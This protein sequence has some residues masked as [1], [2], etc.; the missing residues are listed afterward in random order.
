MKKWFLNMLVLALAAVLLVPVMAQDTITL[1]PF[2]DETFGIQGLMPEGWVTLAPGSISPDGGLTVLVQQAAPGVTPEQLLQALAP[3]LMLAEVPE[4]VE[5][6]EGD[7]L[8]W[9]V[10]FVEVEV[11]GMTILVDLALSE[12]DGATYLVLL[13]ASAEQYETLHFDVFEPVL[14]AYAPLGADNSG[15]PE[16]TAA[17]EETQNIYTDPDGLYEVEIPTN[18]TLEEG[19]GYIALVGPEGDLSYSILTL[20]TDDLTASIDDAWAIFGVLE[21]LDTNYD[22]DMYEHI[23]DQVILDQAGVEDVVVVTYEDGTNDDERIVQLVSQL[24]DGVGYYAMVQGDVSALQRRLA[25]LQIINGSF[26]ILAIE[27]D[28]LTGVEPNEVTPELLAELESFIE[29]AMQEWEVPGV[30]V[31]IVNGDEVLYSSGF[32]TRTLGEESPVSADTLMMIGSTTKSMTTTVMGM[33]VDEGKLDWDEPVRNVLP[34]FQVLDEDLSET[35]TIANLACACTGVPRRDLELIFNANDLTAEGV[36]ES[37][38]TFEFFTDFGEAFQYSNQLVATAGYVAAAANGGEFG[39]L[40][41]AYLNMMQT[42]LFDPLGMD[43]TIIDQSDLAQF[44]DVAT[45]YGL[46]VYGDLVENP[47]A[48]EYFAIPIAPA[49]AVWSTADDMA[50]YIMLL[51]ND[52]VDAAGEQLVSDASLQRVWTPG[53]AMGANANYGLGWIIEDWKG[54]ELISHGGNTLGFSS[55]L[56]FIRDADLG[57]VVLTNAQASSA[58]GAIARRFMELVYGVEDSDII[59]P[60]QIDQTE[61]EQTRQEFYDTLVKQASD[62]AIA[63]FTGD[64]TNEALGDMVISVNEDGELVADMG[65]FATPIWLTTDEDADPNTYIMELPPLAG[66]G[67]VFAVADDGTVTVTIGAGLVEYTFTKTVQ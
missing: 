34:E 58:P 10:Y 53:V 22:D 33:L 62:D 29:Q 63:Q 43:H 15:E 52:G 35:I 20:E 25:Q 59:F 9:D 1:V 54:L 14:V 60:S 45:S 31:A 47:L 16:A 38:S 46:N 56:G 17:P 7:G 13:Q 37:L 23:Q 36:I 65:E 5:Q 8:T 40:Y 50:Q 3:T 39:D 27:E 26:K 41:D 48:I 44:D 30:A 2:E 49:G 67:Y 18:W 12:G 19:D 24:Y 11:Q 32:G 61:S 55:E 6:I 51:L 57:I 28:D 66:L 4:P 64:Y 21:G 42:R